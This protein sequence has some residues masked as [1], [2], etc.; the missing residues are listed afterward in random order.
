[1]LRCKKCRNPLRNV[2]I[3]VWRSNGRHKVVG[4]NLFCVN[5]RC[6]YEIDVKKHTTK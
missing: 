1:M 2:D 3:V 4:L 5:P 6:N